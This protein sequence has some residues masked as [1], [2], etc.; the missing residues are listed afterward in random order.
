MPRLRETHIHLD[1]SIDADG[2]GR[3]EGGGRG[4]GTQTRIFTVFSLLVPE[5]QQGL[6]YRFFQTF[7]HK[8]TFL[9]SVTC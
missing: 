5:H 4:E 9:L 3:G 6:V 2:L 8:H 7:L 1:K